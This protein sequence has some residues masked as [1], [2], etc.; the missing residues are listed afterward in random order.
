MEVFPIASAILNKERHRAED[1][2]N[3][4]NVLH[5]RVDLDRPAVSTACTLFRAWLSFRLAC[6][7]LVVRISK[8]NDAHTDRNNG[9]EYQ[10]M[11]RSASGQN[12]VRGARPRNA[13]SNQRHGDRGQ[14]CGKRSGRKAFASHDASRTWSL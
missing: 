10:Q 3:V 7:V 12:R 11:T 4:I 13:N 1:A 2:T 9:A 6:S 8:S 14:Q 5:I